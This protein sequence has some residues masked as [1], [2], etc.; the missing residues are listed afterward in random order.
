MSKNICICKNIQYVF[1][2]GM[3]ISPGPNYC[4]T[5]N[6]YNWM[7]ILHFARPTSFIISSIVSL[8]AAVF[9]LR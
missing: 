9:I 8:E 5:L 3:Y 1:D 7:D 2:Y 4:Y 6:C